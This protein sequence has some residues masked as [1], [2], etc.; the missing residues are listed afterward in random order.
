MATPL[1]EDSETGEQGEIVL[2]FVTLWN[3][4]FV[5]NKYTFELSDVK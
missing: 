5:G 1:V 4:I 2:V 3:Q